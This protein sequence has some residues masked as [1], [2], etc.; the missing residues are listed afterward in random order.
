MLAL[1]KS[2]I[3]GFSQ[4]ILS[5]VSLIKFIIHAVTSLVQ[6][7]ANLPRFITFATTSLGVLP[8]VLIPFALA[9]VSIY[10]VLRLIN[11]EVG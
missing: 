2:F 8:T 3:S 11:R 5:V 6:F 7:I 4:L 9:G 1:F 10:F